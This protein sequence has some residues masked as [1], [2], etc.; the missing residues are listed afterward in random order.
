M[1][2]IEHRI[3]HIVTGDNG[4]G[5]TRYLSEV[6]E[7]TLKELR[8][9]ESSFS[10]LICLSGT[11]FEKFP[12]PHKE[13]LKNIK[14][15]YYYFGYKAN[16]NMFSDIT[17]FRSIVNVILNNNISKKSID[18]ATSLM[19][20][21]GFKP[22]LKLDFRRARNSKI[23]QSLSSIY[24]DLYDF[25]NSTNQ[26]RQLKDKINDGEIHLNKIFFQKGL[27]N[28][29]AVTDLS[30]GERQFLLTI[31]ALTFSI[32]NNSLILF[33]EPENSMHPSWQI[34]IA[35]SISDVLSVFDKTST[36]IIATHSPL[37]VS[38]IPNTG[39]KITN[40]GGDN[41]S[42]WSNQILSGNNADSI[43]KEQFQLHSSR[44]FETLNLIQKCLHALSKNDDSFHSHQNELKKLNLILSPDDPLF[45]TYKTIIEHNPNDSR[46]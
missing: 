8:H 39:N 32:T 27:C 4:T 13:L 21:I 46:T 34:K 37:V 36:C 9:N 2:A 24:F 35:K 44:S 10:R 20:E 40:L 15:N 30:S 43:L 42:S 16:N 26:L 25:D 18:T 38:S 41:R 14:D 29:H 31:L 33:D 3:I 1:Q 6:S 5:K 22:S 28:E 7:K 17:P 45:D 23:D 12:K 19:S 11:V